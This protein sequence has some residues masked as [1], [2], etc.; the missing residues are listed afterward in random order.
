MKTI[1][2]YLPQFHPISE[3]N[4]WWGPGFT[5]WRRVAKARPR[6]RGH[7]QPHLPGELGFYDLRLEQTREAQAELARAHGISGFCYYHFWFNGRMLLEQPFNEVLESGRPALPFCLCWANENWTRHRER[8]KKQLLIGQSY[9]KYDVD[10]HIDWLMR[11]FD[12]G[13]YI[14]VDGKPLFIVHTPSDIPDPARTVDAWQR[15]ASRRGLD[16]LYLCGVQSARNT[17]SEAELI[18]AGFD[19][20]I[21]FLPRPDAR[22]PRDNAR[23]STDIL[24]RAVNYLLRVLKLNTR[25]SPL[26]VSNTFSYRGLADTSRTKLNGAR[27]RHPCVI[28]GWDDS[29]R[30]REG[31]NIYQ[32]DDPA[33]YGDWLTDALVSV[34]GKPED[35]QLVFVNA[36]N[37]WSKGCHL[38]PDCRH[39]RAFLEATREAVANARAR[40][41]DVPPQPMPTARPAVLAPG[42][43][44]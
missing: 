26:P 11:A 22:G 36:W 37:E 19:A 12:D 10:A 2:F 8:G 21:D 4:A 43:H 7:Y 24:P 15:A 33:V 40:A 25:L 1:C 6:F 18:A 38:E 13:R 32:N 39:G 42:S 17:L 29:P 23:L 27:T 41:A 20:A 9:D 30:R 34:I 3:N 35:E 44:A 5:E 16:G 14:R 31:V 28:P